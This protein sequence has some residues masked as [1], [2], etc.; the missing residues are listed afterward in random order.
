[1]D[2][3]EIRKK[4]QK[5][6]VAVEEQA[7]LEPTLAA[8]L[9]A[10]EESEL[11]PVAPPKSSA[12]PGLQQFFPDLNFASEEDYIQGISGGDKGQEVETVQ[13]LTFLLGK[14]EYA[15]N[16]DVVMELIKPRAYTE[17]PDV[18][19]Y[20]R[21]IL[22]LRGEVVPVIDLCRRLK[23]G[24]SSEGGYQRIVV[25]EGKEQSI[26]LLV[27]RITQVVRIPKEA[28]EQAPLVVNEGDNYVSGVG[29]YQGRMLILLNPD[30][31][32]QV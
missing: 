10:A 13:W 20:V 18:P 15:L 25:C 6:D 1:M 7:L 2:L 21:G 12:A 22:S 32:L 28:I 16:L 19:D 14:E 24:C 11:E 23:L 4:A 5:K 31:V 26:G 27:D 30:E 9:F 29:R 8:E 3:A 17:L